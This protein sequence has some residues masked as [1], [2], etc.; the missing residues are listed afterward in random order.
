MSTMWCLADAKRQNPG[1]PAP[2]QAFAESGIRLGARELGRRDQALEIANEEDR[3][4]WKTSE[5]RSHTKSAGFEEFLR[6]LLRHIGSIAGVLPVSSSRGS[7]AN[8]IS[9][10]LQLS[11]S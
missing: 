2:T 4:L 6:Q 1:Q 11:P 10:S 3:Q 5:C 8:S 9:K 7:R